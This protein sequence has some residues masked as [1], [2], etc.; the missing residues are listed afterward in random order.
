MVEL[1]L[2][3][4]VVVL[5]QTLYMFLALAITCDEYFVT[6]LEKICE[7]SLFFV[8]KVHLKCCE[9]HA[10]SSLVETRPE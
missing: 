8:Y 7:V 5:L 4:N 6:S 9:I 2:I 10:S 1:K 3:W